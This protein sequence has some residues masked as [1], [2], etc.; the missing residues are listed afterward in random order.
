M[1]AALTDGFGGAWLLPAGSPAL[2]GAAQNRTYRQ[3]VSL[4]PRSLPTQSLESFLNP[5]IYCFNIKILCISN[6]IKIS[7]RNLKAIKS[8]N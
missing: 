1:S 3:S 7:I 5:K 2:D 4:F 6:Y 8:K